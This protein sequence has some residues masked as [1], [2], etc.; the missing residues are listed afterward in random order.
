ME[1]SNFK[2]LRRECLESATECVT[3]D[4]AQAYGSAEDNFGNIADIWNAQGVR[5]DDRK[6]TATDVALMMVGM[7]LA[8]LR[9]NPSHKDSWI[10]V[11]GYAACGMECAC[12]PKNTGYLY[13]AP[14]GTPM[15]SDKWVP[16]GYT[17]EGVD[18]S[19]FFDG[20]KETT[21][22]FNM[23]EV[24]KK[25]LDIAFNGS[26]VKWKEYPAKHRAGD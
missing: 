20:P 25:N 6:V 22:T 19:L 24:T 21:M 14:M 18:E 13:F 11:A 5:I 7:K 8:R 4:R 23:D 16:L 1:I 12:K 9:Y 15:D 3:K 26:G 2:N 17:T 10:D